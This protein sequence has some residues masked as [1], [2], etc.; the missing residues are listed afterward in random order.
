MSVYV[1]FQVNVSDAE[2]YAEY[3]KHSPRI[4]AEY[5]GRAIVR[6]GNPEPLEGA[7]GGNRIVIVEFPDR[8]AARGF[9]HSP[10]YQSIIPLRS[11]AAVA[12]GLIVDA[13]PAAAWDEFVTASRKH[14][15]PSAGA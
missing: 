1:V 2:R 12:N 4:I 9:Y 7:L 15:K 5:G 8:E 11:G 14:G 3:A 6:G 13:L 10:D